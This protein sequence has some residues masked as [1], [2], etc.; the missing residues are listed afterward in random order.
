MLKI[1]IYSVISFFRFLEVVP[2]LNAF[3]HIV[4]CCNNLFSLVIFTD[5][6][7]SGPTQIALQTL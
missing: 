3:E 2:G 5:G 6:M 7:P 1:P 4:D